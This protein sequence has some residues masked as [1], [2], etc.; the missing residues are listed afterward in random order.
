MIQDDAILIWKAGVAAVHGRTLVKNALRIEGQQLFVNEQSFSLEQFD[1]VLVV[2]GGKF[3]HFMAEGIESVFE[4]YKT[5]PR[6]FVTVPDGSNAQVNLKQIEAR[7]CRPQGINL[8]TE[9]VIKATS[10]MLSQLNTATPRT[11]VI[12]L[13]SGGGSALL[14]AST[15]P[16]DD[17]VQ[18][19]HWLSSRGADIIELNKVRIALSNVKGGGLARAM[20][21]GT[22][23][24]LIVS[25]VPGDDIQYVSSGPTVE[26][27]GE[28]VTDAKEVLDRFGAAD[29]E[30]F[31]RSAFDYLRTSKPNY[32]STAQVHNFLI[33]NANVAQ[34]AATQQAIDLGYELVDDPLANTSTCKQIASEVRT[35]L[36]REESGKKC[37]ISLGEPTVEP[38]DGAGQGG[39]NQH[40]VLQTA[41]RL[42]GCQSGLKYCFLSA[43]TDGEDGNTAVAG[44]FVTHAKLW[45]V[46]PFTDELEDHLERFDSHV[47]L[48]KHRMLFESGPTA[49][50]VA[51]LRVLLRDS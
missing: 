45:S 2:G 12:A 17:C 15:L 11:L 22:M 34:K 46:L 19:T 40:A 42:I 29:A 4:S 41:D 50:N 14:E 35:W 25:D 1:D 20:N 49:T 21:S 10:Q 9:R 47:F 24:S 8:P 27:S 43:G 38:G 6:G 16:L 26:Y 32:Q 5:L 31:P 37:A 39:R 13:I 18:A 36:D 7:E 33:G 30:G 3:S 23:I 51:D 48:K 28:A 44:A